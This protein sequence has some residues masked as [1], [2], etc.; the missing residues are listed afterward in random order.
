MVFSIG[1][2]AVVCVFLVGVAAAVLQAKRAAAGRMGDA[3]SSSSGGAGGGADGGG[4]AQQTRWIGDGQQLGL[5]GTGDQNMPK[6]QP[7]GSKTEA[8]SA[9]PDSMLKP[10]PMNFN[11]SA[12]GFADTDGPSVGTKAAPLHISPR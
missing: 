10:A 7:W 9:V 1:A 5:Y 4:S 11:F 12:G 3:G 6:P 2:A 8:L